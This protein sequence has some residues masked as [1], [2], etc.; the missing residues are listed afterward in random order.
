MTETFYVPQNLSDIFLR[1]FKK[2]YVLCES[3]CS[4]EN[5][6]QTFI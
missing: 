3:K 2:N 4:V 5:N 6:T 1:L